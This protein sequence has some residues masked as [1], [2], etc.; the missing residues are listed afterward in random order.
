MH[1]DIFTHFQL[2][3]SN[4]VCLKHTLPKKQL[5]NFHSTVFKCLQDESLA[6]YLALYVQI[7]IFT[8]A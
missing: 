2:S 1:M 7:T 8:Y 4:T 5:S 3:S 6:D